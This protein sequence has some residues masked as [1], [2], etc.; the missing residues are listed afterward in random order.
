MVTVVETWGWGDLAV[1]LHDTERILLVTEVTV[2]I[3]A[4]QKNHKYLGEMRFPIGYG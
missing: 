4:P 3:K 2:R 1:F